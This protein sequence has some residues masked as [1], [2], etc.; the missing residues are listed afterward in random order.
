[1]YNKVL[2]GMTITSIIAGIA[3]A[4]AAT[5]GHIKHRHGNYSRRTLKASLYH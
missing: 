3:M 2:T 4:V 1:M 5:V